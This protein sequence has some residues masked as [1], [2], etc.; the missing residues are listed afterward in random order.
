MCIRDRH[1]ELDIPFFYSFPKNSCEGASIFFGHIAKLMFPDIK[2][3]I[4][5]GFRMFSEDD[6][7]Y[8][9][10]VEINGRIFDLTSDQFDEASEPIINEKVMGKHI[11]FSIEERQPVSDYLLYYFDNCLDIKRFLSI[12]NKLLSTLES[13]A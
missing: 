7:G 11:G 10:W 1:K 13:Y 8:H 5:K 3:A 9:F 2:I 12:R 6:E 4:V